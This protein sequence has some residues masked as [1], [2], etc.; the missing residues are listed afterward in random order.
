MKKFLKQTL[1]FAVVVVIAYPLLIVLS[2]WLPIPQ[3]FK[4]SINYKI[5]SYGHMYSR[6]Q[7]ARTMQSGVDILFLGSSH[8]YRG[9]DPRNFEP[10][11]TFNLGSSSQTPMQTKILL[12][13]YLDNIN[14]KMVVYEVYPS[15]LVSDGVESS[16]DL[17]A[18]DR[19]DWNSVKMAL[20]INN[21]KT[22][23]TLI[24]GLAADWLQ[25]NKGFEEPTRHAEDTYILCG[26]VQRDMSYHTFEKLG[27]RQWKLRDDQLGKFN[28]CLQILR[29]RNIETVL[30]F[31]PIAPNVYNA[32]TNHAY[33]DSIFNSYGLKYYDF[34]RMLDLNDSLHF[35]DGHHLNQD[36]VNI[37]NKKVREVLGK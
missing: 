37:F 30:V 14:P 31:A 16:L 2:M 29:D 18:N 20:E 12:E 22:Y 9:F 26:Y 17:I 6:L 32:Y 34:N 10:L 1:L 19:N 28:E 25:L 33:T 8:T 3:V 23:N 7:E 36:G 21:I 5:G 35:Y 24:Y 27:Q 4:P 13:R 15:T 11:K